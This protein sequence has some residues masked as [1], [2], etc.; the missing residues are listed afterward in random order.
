[1]SFNEKIEKVFRCKECNLVPIINYY[2]DNSEEEED[3][4]EQKISIKCRNNHSFEDI[5][6]D[7]F[8]EDYIEK[9]KKENID[10]ICQLHDKKIE[11]ICKKCELNLCNECQHKCE[12]IVNIKDYY[13]SEKEKDEIK[14]NCK[15][16]GPFFDDLKKKVNPDGEKYKFFYNNNKRL[17]SFAEIIFSTYLK[18]EKNDNLSFE[19]IKNCRF[20]LKFK[21]KKLSLENDSTNVIRS[22]EL[23]K[24]I[25]IFLKISRMDTYE[26]RKKHCFLK[27][28]NYIIIPSNDVDESK[29]KLLK[30]YVVDIQSIKDSSFT[31]FAELKD[32]KFAMVEKENINIYKNDSFEIL[33][34][35]TIN[36]FVDENDFNCQNKISSIFCLENGNLMATTYDGK[37]YIFKIKEN[38][39]EKIFEISD[40][41]HFLNAIELKNR[42]IIAFCTSKNAVIYSF[43]KKSKKFEKETIINIDI[44][45][46]KIYTAKLI[47]CKDSENKFQKLF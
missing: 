22:Y 31:S 17:L 12:E 28:K 44:E 30:D 3:S 1:M 13:L 10:S 42:K 45:E 41:E 16:F 29:Y 40:N 33:Y 18:Y 23:P 19:I 21:Y 32:D 25:E 20:C 39:Y 35:I 9:E 27:P 5:D 36:V 37:I 11:K 2:L 47:D 26:I 24:E 46:N 8:L 38:S 15:K 43:N 34:T 14:E 7:V 4:L 6:L